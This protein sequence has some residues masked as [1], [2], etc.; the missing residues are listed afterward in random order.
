MGY[1]DVEQPREPSLGR[2]AAIALV[3]VGIALAG[4]L[5]WLVLS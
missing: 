4:C 3:V 2:N 1:F 5:A